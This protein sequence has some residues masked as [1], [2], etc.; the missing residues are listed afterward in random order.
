M[1]G[2]EVEY[3][4]IKIPRGLADIIDEFRVNHKEFSSRTDVVKQA[5]RDY[6]D[7]KTKLDVDHKQTL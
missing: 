6:I 1:N 2:A 7:S 4:T 3:T 5:V